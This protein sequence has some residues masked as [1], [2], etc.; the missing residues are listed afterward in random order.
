M[1]LI[2]NIDV[3]KLNFLKI[4]NHTCDIT[5]AVNKSILASI[6]RNKIYNTNKVSDRDEIK[7]Y[8]KE[9]L[10]NIHERSNDILASEENFII[11]I[12]TLKRNMLSKFPNLIQFR[13]SH[14]QKSINV[15]FKH[16]WCMDLI[17]TPLQCPVDRTILSI[18]NAP[19]NQRLWGYIDSIEEYQNKINFLREKAKSDGFD[20][21]AIWELQNFKIR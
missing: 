17:T 7:R 14:S 3:Y 4:Y 10:S 16:L 11:E 15:F 8:W 9:Q 18:A 2:L 1:S 6:Q 20:N 12:E 21:L 13:I 19:I 5:V